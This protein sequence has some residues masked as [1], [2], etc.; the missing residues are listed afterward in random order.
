M[1]QNYF[2]HPGMSVGV[3]NW[4]PPSWQKILCVRVYLHNILQHSRTFPHVYSLCGMQS[5]FVVS[6]GKS[7]VWPSLGLF[8]FEIYVVNIV[9]LRLGCMHDDVD[10]SH[11]RN[12]TRPSLCSSLRGQRSYLLCGRKEDVETRLPTCHYSQTLSLFTKWYSDNTNS[13]YV[14]NTVCVITETQYWNMA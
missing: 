1:P 6:R 9:H 8:F 5:S 10:V 4:R 14:H 3:E 11:T 12:H 7:L 13:V 2:K